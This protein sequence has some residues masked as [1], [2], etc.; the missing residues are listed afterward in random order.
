MRFYPHQRRYAD[1]RG[2][3]SLIDPLPFD[4]KRV[5]WI[6][7]VPNG[8]K[9]GGHAHPSCRQLIQCVAGAFALSG[10]DKD[11][12]FGE[13]LHSSSPPI[14][15]EPM[16]WIELSTF[17]NDAVCLVLAS[18]PWSEPISSREEFDRLIAQ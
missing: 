11:R 6:S 5:F 10:Q 8:E 18:E 17:T 14:L 12:K 15:V 7:D 2:T 1:A 4:P 3:L 16:T 13:I 9:R